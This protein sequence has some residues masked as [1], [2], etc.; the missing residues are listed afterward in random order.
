MFLFNQNLKIYEKHKSVCYIKI[1][2]NFFYC[3]IKDK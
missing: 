1:E 3:K 2:K